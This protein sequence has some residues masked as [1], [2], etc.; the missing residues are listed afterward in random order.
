MNGSGDIYYAG[1]EPIKVGLE[2]PD[3]KTKVIATI[4]MKEG[5]MCA[6]GT[7][8]RAWDK[9][10]HVIDPHSKT[11]TEKIV[12]TWVIAKSTGLADALASCLFFVAPEDLSFQNFEYCIMNK[13][14]RIKKS[15]ML[16]LEL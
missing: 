5:A 11:S 10:H 9:Y 14:R 6:S 7:N 1:T 15:P 3:D 12:A 4:E 2:D 8:R 16:L 13:E